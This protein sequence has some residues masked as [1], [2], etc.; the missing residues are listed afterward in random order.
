ME[1]YNWHFGNNCFVSFV[2]G[3]PQF[4]TGCQIY[5]SMH[6]EGVASMSDGA[7]NVLFYTDGMTVWNTNNTAMPNG[8]GLSGSYTSSQSA[9]IVPMPGNP[10]QYYVF[11][12]AAY[13]GNGELRYSVADMTL[14]GGS[15]DLI[16]NN[17]LVA[18]SMT[19]KQIAVR[20]NNGIDYWLITHKR[21]TNEFQS[22]LI[23]A[24]G[25]AAN[26]VRSNVGST[27][28]NIQSVGCMKATRSGNKIASAYFGETPGLFEVYDF[29]NSTGILNNPVALQDT[30]HTASY[31]VEFS[32]DERFLYGS[33]YGDKKIYQYD[34]QAASPVGILIASPPYNAGDMLLAPDGKI[35]I[36]L[37]N[38]FYLGVINA[39]DSAGTACDFVQNGFGLGMNSGSI[40]LPNMIHDLISL[41]PVENISHNEDAFKIFPNPAK[42]EFTVSGLQFPVEKIEIFNLLGETVFSQQPQTSNFKLQTTNLPNGIYII[43]A[44][45][46]KGV[47]QQKLLVNH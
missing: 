9:L 16:I 8:T 38:Y 1:T 34:L 2:T 14:A 21:L 12:L 47:F 46:D 31:S 24:S 45:T 42:D 17:V 43:K 37:N 4:I 20:H 13:G 28:T 11:S 32:P 22:Y 18:D 3:A 15:G 29:D 40:G 25:V 26:P 33:F 27:I 35:Y 10:N 19:E 44:Y 39:P 6:Q 23:N 5:N 30:S 41:V 36:V 7:G